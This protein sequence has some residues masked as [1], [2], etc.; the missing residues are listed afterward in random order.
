MIKRVL[1]V[2]LAALVLLLPASAVLGA[3]SGGPQVEEAHFIISP[4]NTGLTITEFL[5]FNNPDSKPYSGGAVADPSGKKRTAWLIPLPGG[6]RNLQ[7]NGLENSDYAGV[8][9]GIQVYK[10]IASGKST[11]SFSYTLPVSGLPAAVSKK[12]PFTTQQFFVIAPVSAFSVK[13]DV[14]QDEGQVNF[15]NNTYEQLWGGNLAAG[16]VVNITVDQPQAQTTPSNNQLARGF[17]VKLH[18]AGHVKLFMTDPLVYT[19]PHLW[20]AYLFIMLGL[21]IAAA[22]LWYRGRFGHEEEEPQADSGAGDDQLFL[23]LKAKQD[24]LLQR[25]KSLDDRFAAGQMSEQEYRESREKY[26]QLLVQV[27]LQLRELA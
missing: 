3:G 25:I 13:A 5:S 24:L 16:T 12:I 27:K 26:K 17:D 21:G 22:I 11:F 8:P 1:G 7:V 18:P 4:G 14:L 6:Y 9:D 15:N 20:A 10:A 19:N 2:L 23:R